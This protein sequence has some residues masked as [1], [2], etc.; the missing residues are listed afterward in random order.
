MWAKAHNYVEWIGW[1]PEALES[2]GGISSIA[3]PGG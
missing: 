2:A 1:T 3:A